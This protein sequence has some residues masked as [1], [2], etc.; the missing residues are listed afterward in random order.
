LIISAEIL[1][2]ALVAAA[3]E[4]D[5]YFLGMTL[6]SQPIIAGGIAGYMF[7]DMR[8]GILIGTMVQ[9]IWVYPPVG[10]FVPPSSTAIAFTATVLSTKLLT[11]QPAPEPHSAIMMC[12]IAGV[13]TGYFVGQLDIWNR[14]LNTRIV[15][16][17]ENDILK[18]SFAHMAAVQL[19]ALLAKFIRD[20]LLYAVMFSYGAFLLNKIYMTLSADMLQ[21]L[22]FAYWA[23]PV[24]GFAVIFELFRTKFGA[25]FHGVLFIL[26]YLMLWAYGKI[27]PLFFMLAVLAA[28]GLV[29]YNFVWN[30][31]EV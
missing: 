27:S 20:I 31:K 24:I 16:F 14:K 7:G 15:R 3:L 10:A 26:S 18:G 29:I 12:I 17:F 6:V 5:T 9:L 23:M 2:A 22:T 21:G 11:L 13:G 4:L 28:C 1:L 30:R 25:N 8:T 19:S